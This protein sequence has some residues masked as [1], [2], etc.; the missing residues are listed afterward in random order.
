MAQL[1]S[2]FV[3]MECCKI[4]DFYWIIIL[5]Q[6]PL[7]KLLK[8]SQIKWKSDHKENCFQVDPNFKRFQID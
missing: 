2:I 4:K 8:L 3:C 6:Q 5:Q 7:F 1:K